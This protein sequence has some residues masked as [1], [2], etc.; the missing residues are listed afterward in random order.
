MKSEN[1]I[2]NEVTDAI[3]QGVL[4]ITRAELIVNAIIIANSLGRD[5]NIED[6]DEFARD[7]LSSEA[8][9]AIATVEDILGGY[10][11]IPLIPDDDFV[12]QIATAYRVNK[13]WDS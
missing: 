6:K 8:L 11:A 7:Y 4:G 5:I 13:I 2:I 10:F 12:L 1:E 9:R 3:Y